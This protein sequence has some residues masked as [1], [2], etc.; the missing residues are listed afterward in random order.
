MDETLGHVEDADLAGT[1]DLAQNT[2]TTRFIVFL[3]TSNK[4]L[5]WA[6]GIAT[7]GARTLR[8]GLLALLLGARML[9]VTRS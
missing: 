6:P 2:F 1:L 8:T 7:N 5:L 3:L 9:L 4:K